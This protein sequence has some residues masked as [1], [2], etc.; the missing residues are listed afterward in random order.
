MLKI[1]NKIHFF[2]FFFVVS[3]HG[4]TPQ[5]KYSLVTCCKY[6]S[7][8]YHRSSKRRPSYVYDERPMTSGGFGTGGEPPIEIRGFS[9]SNAVISCGFIAT[10]SSFIEY[11]S[12]GNAG[13]LSSLGFVYGLPIILVGSALKYGEI[14]P[15]PVKSSEYAKIIFEQK[16]TATIEK[17]NRDVTRHRYGDEAHLDTTVKALGLVIRGKSYPQLEYLEY[18]VTEY[19]ELEFTMVWKSIDTPFRIWDDKSMLENYDIYFG[20]GIWSKVI[21]VSG[22]DRLVGIKLTTGERSAEENST[23]PLG[24]WRMGCDNVNDLNKEI[25]IQ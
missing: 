3:T 21:K 2:M 1:Y 24:I 10:M 23:V 5:T 12:G 16:K 11:L 14:A 13:G 8:L 18:G 20:P 7:V 25:K 22:P 4:F 6:R 15:V 9:L 17:I 19:D